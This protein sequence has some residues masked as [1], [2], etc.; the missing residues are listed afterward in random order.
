MLERGLVVLIIV[1]ATILYVLRRGLHPNSIIGQKTGQVKDFY[2]G[3]WMRNAK[4][5][6]SKHCE[7]MLCGEAWKIINF[8]SGILVAGHNHLM[9]TTSFL[10]LL[11]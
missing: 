2:K 5:R 8:Q 7:G 6:F 4:D 1:T 3:G 10:F 11:Q 9:S